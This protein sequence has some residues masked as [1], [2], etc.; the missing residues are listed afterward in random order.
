[1]VETATTPP[2]A[3][4]APDAAALDASALD[5]S[6][7][8]PHLAVADAGCTMTVGALLAANIYAGVRGSPSRTASRDRLDPPTRA[9]WDGRD[10]GV[11]YLLCKYAVRMNGRAFTYEHVA[12]QNII[13]QST[14]LDTATC[15]AAA[16]RKQVAEQVRESTN[17][18]A[19][20]HAGAYW[21]FD[22]VPA[23]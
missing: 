13:S 2:L 4:A 12:A 20:P 5:A 16:T 7:P 11:T 8:T 1:M 10:H 15:S 3:A 23:D 17:E 6:A 21:G 22:L 18:C 14:P 9:R 19:D